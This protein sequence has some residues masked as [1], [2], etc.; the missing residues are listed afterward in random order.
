MYFEPFLPPQFLYKIWPQYLT[1][2]YSYLALCSLDC[3]HHGQCQGSGCVCQ[4]GWEGDR[5]QHRS[6]DP[7]CLLHG[8]CKNGS[9]VCQTGFNGRHCTLPACTP[10]GVRQGKICNGHGTCELTLAGGIRGHSINKGPIEDMQYIGGNSNTFTNLESNRP[11][12]R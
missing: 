9:C 5:C 2:L 10:M 12:Y 4:E 11:E 6:C 3:S 8:Q 7:R 1:I